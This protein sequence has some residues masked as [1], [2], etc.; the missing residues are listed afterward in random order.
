MYVYMYKYI[1]IYP[2]KHIINQ[3]TTGLLTEVKMQ[4]YEYLDVN[5][6]YNNKRIWKQIRHFFLDKNQSYNKITLV[7]N[8]EIIS[9]AVKCAEI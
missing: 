9:D 6:V 2:K 4:F 3:E 7:E 8:N 5:F 1:Y